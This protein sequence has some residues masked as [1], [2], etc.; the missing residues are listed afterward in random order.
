MPRDLPEIA[1][2]VRQP[3]AWA[4]IFAGK[5]VENRSAGSIRVGKMRPGRIALH[6]ASGMREAE[7]AWAVWR[8]A[9]DGVSVPPPGELVRGA[10][11]GSVE[12]VEIITESDSPWFGGASG[13]SLKDPEPIEPIPCKGALGYFRW[14]RAKAFAGPLLWMEK[15]P[16]A[17][18]SDQSAQS[19]LFDALE[20]Q[21]KTP[22]PK[23]FGTKK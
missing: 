14:E 9:Q 16:T 22:P 12:V 11:I 20:V 8:M 18:T 6:A 17:Q 1:L 23:P 19:G 7:Y 21:F 2:S 15:W 13:L 5:D 4:I 3:W 10:I